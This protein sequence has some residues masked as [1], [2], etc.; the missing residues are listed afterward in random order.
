MPEVD[1]VLDNEAKPRAQSYRAPAA[2]VADRHLDET[3]AH[4]IDGFEGRARAFVQVQQG[5]D[6]RCTFCVIP[7]ARGPNRSVPIGAVPS[8]PAGWSRRAIARSC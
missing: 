4:L 1:R 5:C 8:R 6:H 2:A 7:Y 3:A